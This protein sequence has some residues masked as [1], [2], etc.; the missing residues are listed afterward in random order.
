MTLEARDFG[1]FFHAI[2]GHRPFPWQTKLVE[3]LA[4]GEGWPEVIDI[5]TGAGKT[6]AL[7]AAV[8]H[9]A[10]DPGASRRIV[11]VVDRR[12]I[13]DDTLAHA[14]RIEQGLAARIDLHPAVAAV[15]AR[16]RARA[17]PDSPPLV[18][19]RLSGGAPLEPDWART[20][21]QPTILCSTV[22]QVGSRLLFRGY[23][24]SDRMLPVHAGLLGTDTLFLL[25]EAHL[26]EPFRQTLEAVRTLGRAR[27]RSALLSA[28]P[29]TPGKGR[30]TLRARDRTH[31]VLGSRLR[32]E[33]PTTLHR[34][35][36]GSVDALANAF[37]RTARELLAALSTGGSPPHAIGIVVNRVDLA[38]LAFEA[39]G[40]QTEKILLIGRARAVERDRLAEKLAPFRTGAPRNAPDDLFVVATQCLEAGVD[41]DLDGLVTQAAPLDALRQ[42]FGRLNRAGRA[43]RATGAI[44]AAAGDVAAE[45]DDPVY[46]NRTRQTWD[47]LQTLATER[48]VDFGTAALERMLTKLPTDALAATLP[49]APVIMPAYLD[50]WA[51]TAP[52]PQAD[53]DLALFL[54][55]T[56]RTTTGVSIVWRADLVSADLDEPA[57]HGPAERLCLVPPLAAEAI[58]V[59]LWTARAWLQG[60]GPGLDKTS[61][62]AE[63]PPNEVQPEDPA[64]FARRAFRW[65][66]PDDPRTRTVWPRELRPGDLIVVPA[67]Y[68]GCD[69]FGWAPTSLAPAEDV[70]ERAAEHTRQRRCTLRIHPGTT[71]SA[72]TRIHA[73]VEDETLSGAA[74]AEALRDALDDTLES[75]NVAPIRDTLAAFAHARSAIDR[76]NPYAGKPGAGTVLVAE[77]GI[78]R[79]D[80]ALCSTPATEADILSH[81]AE[82]PITLV[83]HSSDVAIHAARFG[84]TLDLPP[85]LQADITLAAWLQDLGKADP[86]FQRMLG[87]RGAEHLLAKSPAPWSRDAAGDSGLPAGWRHEA[88]SVQMARAHPHF[89]GAHDPGLVLWLIGTHHGLG[90][91]FFGFTDPTDPT[92]QPCLGVD[93]WCLANDGHG[94]ESLAFDL[95][96]LDWPALY[97]E[98]KIRYGIWGLAH[99]EALVRLADHRASEALSP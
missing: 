36:Q 30:L 50:L 64:R 20:P 16:L 75:V 86:R 47:V 4:A 72:W 52:R 93:A 7:D 53:P 51:Q 33:K 77:G 59:P 76:H 41:V 14:E 79:R 29:G 61:D 18:S 70:A 22:D 39:L 35:I 60:S 80:D 74:L 5:P 73:L 99:L 83:R 82:Y 38:R 87:R 55:G 57:P 81:R 3:R 17:G 11:L 65:A 95:D 46:G 43:V 48:A 28:T 89:T 2:H 62:M 24:V 90:R 32:A 91:P 21:T 88:L 19:A 58:E 27:I 26:A 34:P 94:P 69:A 8:F 97:E 68:G 9:L 54:H 49:D 6:V 45:A 98:L 10:I 63:R 42:R 78:E 12:L 1:A 84:S 31:P 66:G 71:G 25:D 85:E 92:P 67:A 13:V 96:G 15:A 56:E 40:D 44:L 37:A 23:G